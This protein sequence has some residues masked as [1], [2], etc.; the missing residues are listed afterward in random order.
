MT[1]RSIYLLQLTHLLYD[2]SFY[3][4]QAAKKKKK[5]ARESSAG[6]NQ[7]NTNAQQKYHTIIFFTNVH[8]QLVGTIV[9][10]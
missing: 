4:N 1:L 6:M 8:L 9:Y 7:T 3:Q 5:K 2:E 10:K